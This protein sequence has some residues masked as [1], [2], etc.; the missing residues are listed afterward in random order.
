MGKITNSADVFRYGGLRLV[1]VFFAF[2]AAACCMHW[3]SP[4]A[5]PNSSAESFAGQPLLLRAIELESRADGAE[6]LREAI[7]AYEE[8]LDMAP[9]NLEALDKLGHLYLLLGDGYEMSRAKKKACF[10]KAI[11]CNE[12][13]M[14]YGNRDFQKRISAGAR[15]WESLPALTLNEMGAMHF[16]AT[17]IF[18]YYKECLGFFGQIIHFRWIVRARMVMERMSELDPDWGRGMLHFNW[19][20]YYLAIPESLGGDRKKARASFARAIDLGPEFMIF[21]WGRA[22]YFHF[23][24]RD[25]ES[26]KE[27]LRWVAAQNIADFADPYPWRVFFRKDAA[28]ML[29]NFD[30]YFHGRK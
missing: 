18:Y 26:F 11:Q 25:A 7:Q 6:A 19:G 22:K 27:D 1:A 15:L 13:A 16:W 23:K 24:M 3:R 21:R 20:C 14:F 12:R 28:F 17:G 5:A 2:L 10:I 30:Y 29:E 8:V 9:G 4:A